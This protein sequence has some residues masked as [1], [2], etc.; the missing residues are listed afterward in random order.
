MERLYIGYR[1]RIFNFWIYLVVRVWFKS[2]K[3]AVIKNLYFLIALSNR[4]KINL[5]L[6]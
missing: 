4:F 2:L 1:E 6:G 5:P 3:T